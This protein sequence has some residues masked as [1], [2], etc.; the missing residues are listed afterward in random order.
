M[1]MS[2]ILIYYAMAH[3]MPYDM[4]YIIVLP[5]Y[6][7]DEGKYPLNHDFVTKTTS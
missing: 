7:T 2:E 4:S 1:Y 3:S 5:N 6:E